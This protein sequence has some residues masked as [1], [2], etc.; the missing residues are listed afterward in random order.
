MVLPKNIA[1]KEN[2]KPG[3]KI[4]VTFVKHVNNPLKEIFG[5]LK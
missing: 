2:I 1:N 5:T 4:D 3:D